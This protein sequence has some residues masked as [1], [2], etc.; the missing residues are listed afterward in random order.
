M[1][2]ARKSVRVAFPK[3]IR[4]TCA[5]QRASTACAPSSAWWVTLYAVNWVIEDVTSVFV[6]SL[7]LRTLIVEQERRLEELQNSLGKTNGATRVVLSHT[8]Y[9][10]HQQVMPDSLPECRL[11]DYSV[12]FSSALDFLKD[13]WSL[14]ARKYDSVDNDSMERCMVA[15]GFFVL[16]LMDRIQRIYHAGAAGSDKH[17]PLPPV[18]PGELAKPR[19]HRF[20]VDILEPQRPRLA[21]TGDLRYSAKIL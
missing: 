17:P 1:A 8:S 5:H 12:T 19:T 20:I 16:G 4:N 14:A 13:Q 2:V 11:G 6:A 10:D 15:T 7:G 21:S 3:R 9:N 18:T